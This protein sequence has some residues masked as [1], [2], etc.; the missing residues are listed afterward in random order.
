MSYLGIRKKE[1]LTILYRL[2]DEVEKLGINVIMDDKEPSAKALTVVIADG[3]D[4]TAMYS[5]PMLNENGE[6]VM[7]PSPF[8]WVMDKAAFIRWA[9][10]AT[11]GAMRMVNRSIANVVNAMSVDD[12][13]VIR[14]V[15]NLETKVID[16]LRTDCL[17]AGI[18]LKG[19]KPAALLHLTMIYGGI[20]HRE[21]GVER[22]I[23]EFFSMAVMGKYIP[24]KCR[25]CMCCRYVADGT[26]RYC[27]SDIRE[28]FNTNG[29]TFPDSFKRKGIDMT[30]YITGHVGECIGYMRRL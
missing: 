26:G 18:R 12:F 4:A 25:T 5:F 19:L 21:R 2:I 11:H 27:R 9:E 6:S 17:H 8:T 14:R 30:H 3:C 20:L 1:D 28:P 13:D 29:S 10:I 15:S 16:L 24:D 7:V 23:W 22:I